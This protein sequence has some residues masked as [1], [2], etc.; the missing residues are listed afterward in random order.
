MPRTPEARSYLLPVLSATLDAR[1]S[2]SELRGN[3]LLLQKVFE[4]LDRSFY[5]LYVTPANYA[6]QWDDVAIV[7]KEPYGCEEAE[8][9]DASD[10]QKAIIN[11][12]IAKPSATPSESSEVCAFLR[13]SVLNP[14]NPIYRGIAFSRAFYLDRRWSDS[15][16]R[17]TRGGSKMYDMYLLPPPSGKEI[18]V[19]M[20]PINLCRLRTSLPEDLRHYANLIAALPVM[21]YV[22]KPTIRDRIAYLTVQEGFVSVGKSQRRPGVHI[23]RPL[24]SGNGRISKAVK[25]WKQ[26]L[27]ELE[28][29]HLDAAWGLGSLST[30]DD[31]PIDGIYTASSV[32]NSCAVWPALIESPENVTD[33]HGGIEHLRPFLGDPVLLK[34][35]EVCWM[36]D[37][38]PHESLPL[39]APDDDPTATRVFRQYFRLVVGPISVWYTLHNTPN[40]T[41]TLPDAP[42]ISDEDKFMFAPTGKIFPKD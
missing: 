28:A 24:P 39:R 6:H 16:L 18:D 38:T 29:E 8:A 13:S 32:S 27:T 15:C 41:G 31:I 23:E 2:L 21:Y 5:S 30:Y 26:S 36:T 1:C 42:D 35:G 34:A 12:A 37:R 3:A 40:P 7:E 25:E 14:R 20:M 10:A 11:E 17:E 19:N 22:T 4:W 33:A 9:P